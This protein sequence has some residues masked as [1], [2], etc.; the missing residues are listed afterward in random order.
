MF[1]DVELPEQP[2]AQYA[3]QYYQSSPAAAKL[4]Q[5][6]DKSVLA[7]SILLFMLWHTKEVGGK[8]AKDHF[9]NALLALN[10]WRER[11]LA[12]LNQLEGQVG[13]LGDAYLSI[14]KEIE[15]EKVHAQVFEYCLVC[16]KLLDQQKILK[17]QPLNYRAFFQNLAQYLTVLKLTSPPRPDE[18]LSWLASDNQSINLTELKVEYRKIFKQNLNKNN[19]NEQMNLSFE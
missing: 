9:A 14:Q 13:R 6:C 2:F 19:N 8:L 5:Y 1:E 18:L 16:D 11:V 3:V 15:L 4:Q 7:P 10:Q 12:A 17:A